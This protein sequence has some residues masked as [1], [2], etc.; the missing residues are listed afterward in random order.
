MWAV[1][2]NSPTAQGVP[3]HGRR[4]VALELA[5]APVAHQLGQGDLH[6]A[7]ALA[8]AAEG[9][10]VGQ[11]A[12]LLYAD[13]RR[14]QHAAHRA[15]IHPAI[16]V[17]ADRAVDRAVV[18][19]GGAADAAQHLLELGPQHRRTAIVDQHDV[20]LIRSIQVVGPPGTGRERGVDG[21]ILAGGGAGEDAQQRGAVL[22]RGH[23]LLDAGEHDMDARQGLRQ[24][25]VALVGD[26]DAAAGLGDQEIG[27]GDA[28]IGGEEFLAQPGARFR[29]DVA[30]FMEHAIGRQVGVRG[31]EARLPVLPV[32]VER[33][34]NDMRRQL[35][36]ELD[37]VLAE[38]GLHRGDA[39][40]F[41]MVVDR[42]FLADHRLALGHRS[43]VGGAADRQH[44]IARLI[45]GRA[46]V[47]LAAGP[48]DV[49][50]PCFQVEV[51][52]CQR[53]VLDVARDVAE[54]FELWQ[55]G[56]G[57]GAACDEARP[58]A[59]RAPSAARHRRWRGGRF[60]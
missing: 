4:Q 15:G 20:V 14:R 46:P 24:V 2:R 8:L 49:G 3:H 32:E 55:V 30:A 27:A 35:V 54:L 40:A 18:H 39:V 6:R 52:I 23:H 44:G 10:G 36:A 22:D 47:H 26:D 21:K 42:E 41:E 29:Q 28:D 43:R 59:G 19:A 34:R 33:R 60:P 38:I 9:G 58:G 48:L 57:G 50:G 25:A 13:Q 31:A 45:G 17:A 16:G 37:D 1:A 53:V 11:M 56:D 5:L 12:C 51:E 7:D